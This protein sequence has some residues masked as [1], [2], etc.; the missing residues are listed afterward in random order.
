MLPETL[1]QVDVLLAATGYHR[2]ALARRIPTRLPGLDIEVAVLACE[3]LML[4]K[5]LADRPIDA[6]DTVALLHANRKSLDYAYLRKWADELH[7]TLSLDQAWRAAW[8]GE[9][10][11][12]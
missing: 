4:H 7:V 8:P 11:P 3:D 1:L 10:L 6:V 12:D 2:G 5:L 9:P